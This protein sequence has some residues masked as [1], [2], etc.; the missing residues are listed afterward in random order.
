MAADLEA[1]YSYLRGG[2]ETRGTLSR[3]VKYMD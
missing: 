2:V 3:L 1:S